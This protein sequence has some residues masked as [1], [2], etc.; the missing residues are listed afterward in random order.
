M[1]YSRTPL[2][3]HSKCNSLHLS[4]P[5]SPPS[6]S[7]PLP[8]VFTSVFPPTFLGFIV[9]FHHISFSLSFLFSSVLLLYFPLSFS[10]YN[11]S[12]MRDK[13]WSFKRFIEWGHF[14]IGCECHLD[15]GWPILTM[16]NSNTV[17]KLFPVKIFFQ[18]LKCSNM[19]VCGYEKDKTTWPPP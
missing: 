8:L 16:S 1:L 3:T 5:N 15:A 14:Q 18:R 19:S 11:H 7:S 9:Y 4:N 17:R 2:L 12:F 13:F 6:T 10:F